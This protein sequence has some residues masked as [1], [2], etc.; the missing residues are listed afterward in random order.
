MDDA[1]ANNITKVLQNVVEN[2]TGTKA[3]KLGR[4]AAGKTGTTDQNKSAWFVGYTP[5]LSTS[6]T[7]FRNDPNAKGKDRKLLSMNHVGGVDSIHGGDIPAVIWTEYMREALKGTPAKEFPEAEDIGV[8]ADAAGAP[9]PTPPAAP[10]PSVS[11]STSP[12]TSPSMVSPSP[13][14]GGKPSCKPWKLCPPGTTAGTGNGGNANGGNI[15]GLPA[16]G[17][18]GEPSPSNTG[19]PGRPGG[20]TSWG[21]SMGAGADPRP[22]RTREGRRTRCG[23]PPAR[24]APYGRMSA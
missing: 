12:S 20:M 4:P 23:G 15:G 22:P 10:S 24:P 5:Q 17:T 11:P 16:G 14:D 13:S 18:T 2:G 19:R 9:T 3:K 7:L 8:V 6:V 21:T 1:V